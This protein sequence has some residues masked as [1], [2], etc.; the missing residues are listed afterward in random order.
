MPMTMTPTAFVLGIV[1]L[2]LS[3][4]LLAMAR[5]RIRTALLALLVFTLLGALLNVWHANAAGF[6]AE[7]FYHRLAKH[8]EINSP[9]LPNGDVDQ[10]VWNVCM[11]T[12]EIRSHDDAKTWLDTPWKDRPAHQLEQFFHDTRVSSV[13]D[14]CEEQSYLVLSGKDQQHAWNICMQVAGY[15]RR[16]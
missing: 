6:A 1:A 5:T 8:C 10:A 15:F 12:Q 14:A 7:E 2:L 13:N 9:A 4:I 11:I 16:R 3:M